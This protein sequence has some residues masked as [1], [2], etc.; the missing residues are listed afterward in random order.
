MAQERKAFV[1]GVPQDLDQEDLYAIFSEYALVKK[2]WLQKY[3]TTDE[4]GSQ[5]TATPTPRNH[6][7]FG[8]VIFHDANAI[9]ALLGGA[10]S[11][12]ITLRSGALLEVKRALSSNKIGA[13]QWNQAEGALQT[14]PNSQ[15]VLASKVTSSRNWDSPAPS[16]SAGEP[17]GPPAAVT[18]MFLSAPASSVGHQIVQHGASPT[19]WTGADA[20]V[21]REHAAAAHHATSPANLVAHTSC[22]A[23]TPL[24]HRSLLANV[25]MPCGEPWPA[26]DAI[27]E[28]Y[29]A[30][31]WHIP[32]PPGLA[33]A[34]LS[35][36]PGSELRQEQSSMRQQL[37]EAIMQFY[38][39]HRPE[40]LTEHDFIDW[41]CSIYEGR[42]AELDDALRHKY[43]TGLRLRG[44][45]EHPSK[46][47]AAPG[48][49][50]PANTRPALAANL[51]LPSAEEAVPAHGW[52]QP[53]GNAPLVDDLGCLQSK[54]DICNI[55][56]GIKISD[57]VSRAMA[58]QSASFQRR[59]LLQSVVW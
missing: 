4:N 2:A 17:R 52:L 18:S 36:A 34:P 49:D 51:E 1:G 55:R 41:I 30:M 37:R 29:N 27:A 40:K 42:E 54:T 58:G 13:L 20:N 35:S 7:G 59:A 43:G 53:T 8:F 38:F 39:E 26:L 9:D 16:G 31:P 5:S 6:R 23:Q 11:R 57:E 25:G 10:S 46:Q 24:V 15:E 3:R 50:P 21:F 22:T 45:E 14:H 28:P 33:T 44:L 32:A 56:D 19:P 48:A 12:F 47:Q